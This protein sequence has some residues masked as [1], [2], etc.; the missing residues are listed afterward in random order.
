MRKSKTIKPNREPYD[1]LSRAARAE[2]EG[3]GYETRER[4]PWARDGY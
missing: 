2:T 4:A 1:Q 3:G